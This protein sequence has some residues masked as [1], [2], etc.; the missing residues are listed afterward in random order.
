MII[1]LFIFGLALTARCDVTD[2]PRVA[3][4]CVHLSF[5]EVGP[6]QGNT[7]P[8]LNAQ[9]KE[10]ININTATAVELTRL[11]GVGPTLAASIVEHRR[12]H[13]PFK[14]PQDIVVVRRVSAKLYR[15]IAHL[16]RI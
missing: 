12:K 3:Q 7:A 2:R 6:D 15:Q 11:P 1:A 16:I 10:R 13:G 4:E 5:N 8:V 14:R 9:T